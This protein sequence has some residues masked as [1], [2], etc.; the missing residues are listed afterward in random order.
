MIKQKDSLLEKLTD[1]EATNRALR[2]LLRE[3]HQ[4]ETAAIRLGEQR[5]LLMRRLG[6]ADRF[7]EVCLSMC[8]K[9]IVFSSMLQKIDIINRLCCC[10]TIYNVELSIYQQMCYGHRVMYIQ[11]LL[12]WWISYRTQSCDFKFFLFFQN[13]FGLCCLIMFWLKKCTHTL[14]NESNSL[15]LSPKRLAV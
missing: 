11:I 15:S 5:D 4:A 7:N 13:E 10:W 14:T 12:A 1:F 8:E 2:R 6:E 9:F 3:Q